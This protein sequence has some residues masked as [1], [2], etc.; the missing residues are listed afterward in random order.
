MKTVFWVPL[1]ARQTPDG[2]QLNRAIV[3]GRHGSS[4]GR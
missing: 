4:P 3:L 1:L 2:T